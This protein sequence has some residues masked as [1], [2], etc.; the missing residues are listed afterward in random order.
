MGVAVTPQT[1]SAGDARFRAFA[2]SAL[3]AI[4]SA[5]RQGNIVY[6]N[7]SAEGMFGYAAEELVGQPLTVL[8]PERFRDAHREGLRRHLETGETRVIGRVVELAGRRKDGT[9]FPIELSL[10]RWNL[11]EEAFFTGI[12]RDV[13]ER[14]R[15]E[16]ERRHR[17]RLEVRSK[18]QVGPVWRSLFLTLGAGAAVVLYR[19]GIHAGS[20]T[21]AF[22]REGR[23]PETESDTVDAF[24]EYLA[25]SG[26]CVP[27]GVILE[28]DPPRLVFRTKE[29]FESA[30]LGGK[31]GGTACHYL[32][33]LMCGFASELLKRRD[34]VCVESSCEAKGDAACTFEVHQF[35]VYGRR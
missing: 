35:P 23:Q 27:A 12:I 8:M 3:D 4:I 31:T 33:G 34:L 21:Y 5:N 30:E 7:R 20:M 18:M 16:E 28:A 11:G 10:A 1:E 24:S 29:S 15:L 14:K 17:E 22:V 6:L 32:R 2:E 9:E 25:E 26:L 19:A 13:S